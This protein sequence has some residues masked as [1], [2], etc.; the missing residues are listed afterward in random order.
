VVLLLV[1]GSPLESKRIEPFLSRRKVSD[2]F[3]SRDHWLHTPVFTKGTSGEAG[4]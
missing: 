4:I 3:L 2:Y 1:N